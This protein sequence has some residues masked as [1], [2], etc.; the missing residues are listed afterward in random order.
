MD[1]NTLELIEK[2]N[3]MYPYPA[4]EGEVHA[5]TVAHFL[6]CICGY[7]LEEAH[8]LAQDM[9]VLLATERAIRRRRFGEVYRYRIFECPKCGAKLPK[10]R[11]EIYEPQPPARYCTDGSC[12]DACPYCGAIWE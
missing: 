12:P 8:A 9:N 10:P 5:V 4:S 7:P 11:T 1:T 2:L 3:T 6:H